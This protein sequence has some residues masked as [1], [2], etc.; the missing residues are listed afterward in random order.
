MIDLIFEKMAEQHISSVTEIEK[1]SFSTP[2]SEAALSEEL[3]NKFARF[4]VALLNGKVVGYIGSHNV[5]GEVYITNVAVFPEHRNKGI[6]EK[7][8]KKLVET[9]Q[10]ENAGFVTLEVRKSNVSAIK[11]YEKCGFCAVGERKNF[12]EKPCEDAVLMTKNLI[13]TE[14]IYEN[15]RN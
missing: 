9:V 4:F 3:S 14:I 2:W 5:L 10:G 1:Q 15:S 12:Y 8:I 11:L 6:G 13:D 7:L